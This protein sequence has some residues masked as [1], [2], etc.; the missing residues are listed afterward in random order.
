MP[1]LPLSGAATA[2]GSLIPLGWGRVTADGQT[3]TFTNI[4][5][6]YQDLYIVGS[7]RTLAPLLASEDN[8]AINGDIVSNN[9]STNLLWAGAL[10]TAIG[11]GV[12][13]QSGQ[14]YLKV[15]YVP[16]SYAEANIFGTIEAYIP[17]YARTTSFKTILTRSGSNVGVSGYTMIT[18]ATVTSTNAVTSLTLAGNFFYATGTQF[19][20]YGVRTVNQ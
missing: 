14:Q 13:Q 8:W 3:I 15:G 17:N 4:P 19:T 11:A 16:A 9:N 18:V 20:L 10:N 2:K 7:A 5:Q 12:Q 1:I 6:S